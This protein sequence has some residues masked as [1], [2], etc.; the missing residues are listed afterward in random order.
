MPS[1]GTGGPFVT[2]ARELGMT[3]T[4]IRLQWLKK[5]RDTVMNRKL[6]F[7]GKKNK[8]PRVRKARTS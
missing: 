1:W 2:M 4:E 7:H 5:V 3:Y 8:K 6:N